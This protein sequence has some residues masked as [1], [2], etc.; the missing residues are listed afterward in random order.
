MINSLPLFHRTRGQKVL[1]LGSGDAAEPKIRLIE[2]AGGI[3]EDDMQRAIDEGVRLAFVA[4]DDAEA[5]KA[6]AINLRRAGML[7]N[8]VDM[9]DLCD[10]TTPSILDRDPVLIAIGTGG[11][12]AGLA[13]HVRLRLDQLLPQ[14]LGALASAL[15]NARDK[16]R[17]SFPSGADRRRVIDAA[18]KQGGKLDP[19]DAD[20]AEKVGDWLNSPEVPTPERSHTILLTSD[21]PDDLTLKQARLLGVADTIVL[22]GEVSEDLLAR[23]RADARRVKDDQA[24][25]EYPGEIV[26]RLVGPNHAA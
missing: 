24:D 12:S 16:L 19:F 3:I 21:D 11:A 14:S 8:V 26:I 10:F 6:A 15:F 1:V 2:R 13:K 23:G 18:L 25:S 17:K 4:Y 20:S 9:P 22:V 7:V 5:C